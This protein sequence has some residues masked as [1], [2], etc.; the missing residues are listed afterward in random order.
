MDSRGRRW[1]RSPVSNKN[2]LL[3][4]CTDRCRAILKAR[5]REWREEWR[6]DSRG[7]TWRIGA[8]SD[9]V[10]KSLHLNAPLHPNKSSAYEKL[11]KK[12][13]TPYILFFLSLCFFLLIH[14]ATIYLFFLMFGVNEVVH[15]NIFWFL[16]LLLTKIV[17]IPA[18]HCCPQAP[19]L[20][21]LVWDD[22]LP[23]SIYKRIF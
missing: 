11:T 18:S 2:P 1:W 6:A 20:S 4:S 8:Q 7:S 21:S 5:K 3:A 19:L 17:P 23:S 12:T 10:E 22:N 9:G 13:H 15:R 14:T 16:L